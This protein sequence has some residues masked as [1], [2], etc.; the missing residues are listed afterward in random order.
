MHHPEV[1]GLKDPEMT[2][3]V[4][5]IRQDLEICYRLL[6]FHKKE[7]WAKQAQKIVDE[8]IFAIDLMAEERA[9]H[10]SD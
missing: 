4:V 6:S 5:K 3:L 10:G 2:K 8:S 1:V 9:K 7:P